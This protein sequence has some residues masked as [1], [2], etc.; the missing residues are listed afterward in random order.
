MSGDSWLRCLYYCFKFDTLLFPLGE[1]KNMDI[2]LLR[3]ISNT[4]IYCYSYEMQMHSSYCLLNSVLCIKQPLIIFLLLVLFLFMIL[5]SCSLC[6]IW[7][8]IRSLQLVTDSGRHGLE[9]NLRTLNEM[10]P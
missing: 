9:I 8:Q 4:F 6:F 3:G 7:N 2:Y 1:R 5:L 10:F